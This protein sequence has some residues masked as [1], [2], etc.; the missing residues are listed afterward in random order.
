[1]G[2]VR[3]GFAK[4]KAGL[5]PLASELRAAARHEDGIKARLKEDLDVKSFTRMGSQQRGTAVRG[6]SDV[7][8]LAV[9]PLSAVQWGSGWKS[10]KTILAHFRESLAQRYVGTEVNIDANA[11]TVNF[12]EG[13][14]PVDVVPAFFDT[15]AQGL[16][17]GTWRPGFQ[18]PDG[19]GGWMPT[20]PASH[21]LYLE[22]A[23]AGWG[24]R[25]RGIVQLL[26]GWKYARTP[27]LPISS[28]YI[29]LRIAT[30]NIHAVGRDDAT[31]VATI[32]DELNRVECRPVRDPVRIAG[33][34]PAASTD[35]KLERT[36]QAV[37]YAAQHAISAVT[38]ERS[39]AIDEA[40][41]QWRLVFNDAFP[42]RGSC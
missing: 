12:A 21:D 31:L 37:A 28:F 38:A 14:D 20:S 33:N 29:E 10:S 6:H 18:I 39:G 3:E 25:L 40:F 16:V 36:Q 26:K 24:G 32:F 35:A 11:V 5:A 7:D 41:R 27:S 13:D 8:Y 23:D 22:R 42:A 17:D 2:N 30:M 19:L 15:N 34:V 4:Y 9:T 1:M